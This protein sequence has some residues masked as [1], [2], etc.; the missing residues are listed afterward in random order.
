[1]ALFMAKKADKSVT[2]NIPAAA[3]NSPRSGIGWS[4]G[5]DLDLTPEAWNLL[6]KFAAAVAREGL[7]PIYV[8]SGRRS[9]AAQAAAMAEK[10]KQGG[11]AELSIYGAKDIVA[12]LVASPV[13]E[14]IAILQKYADQGRY[15]SRHM[16]G[17]AF[18]VRTKDGSPERA[19]RMLAIAK[20]QGAAEAILEPRPPH[21][22]VSV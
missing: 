4:A 12:E 6:G 16:S 19:A 2:L 3:T 22:H 7:G 15:I 11:P 18:D 5:K 21:L 13:A 9:V 8:T 20:A 14:W 1:M 10:Y 17:R